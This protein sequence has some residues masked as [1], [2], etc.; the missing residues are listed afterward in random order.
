M[1]TRLQQEIHSTTCTTRTSY[2]WSEHCNCGHHSF[3][4]CRPKA[5][6]IG[7]NGHVN[8]C[9][10]GCKYVYCMSTGTS[11]PSMNCTKKTSTTLTCITTG[12]SK[13]VSKNWTPKVHED[14]EELLEQQ[15]H[16][17]RDVTTSPR[18]IPVLISSSRGWA[19]LGEQFRAQLRTF[20]RTGKS[21][22]KP[23]K[24]LIRNVMQTTR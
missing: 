2:T 11:T 8:D 23:C 17:Y 14:G 24:I 10:Q 18:S 5:P 19:R 1:G 15:L 16:D 22:K 7:R 21:A 3:L 9:V 6:V 20:F 12:M 13:T 4:L